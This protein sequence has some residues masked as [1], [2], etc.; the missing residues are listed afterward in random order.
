MDRQKLKRRRQELGLTLQEVAD[1][2]GLTRATIQKYESGTA[3]LKGCYSGM[4]DGSKIDKEVL[5]YMGDI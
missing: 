1:K 2:V 4:I 3:A 5:N